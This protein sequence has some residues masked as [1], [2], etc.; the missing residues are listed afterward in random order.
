MIRRIALVAC[1]I[2][3]ALLAETVIYDVDVFQNCNSWADPPSGVQQ[4]VV[5]T[6]DSIV[7]LYAFI[8]YS[9]GVGRY[10]LRIEEIPG[11]EVIVNAPSIGWQWIGGQLTQPKQVI[12][13]KKYTL[14]FF[15]EDSAVNFYYN[16]NNPYPHGQLTNPNMPQYD[17]CARVWGR[18]DTSGEYFGLSGLFGSSGLFGLSSSSGLI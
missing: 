6:C 16:P 9:P 11:A 15:H 8:G 4:E 12:K 18:N 14:K 10:H 3:S 13:G 5:M 1:V 2:V 7:A 17:L